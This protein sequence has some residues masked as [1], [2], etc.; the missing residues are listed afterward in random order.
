[1]IYQTLGFDVTGGVL[2]KV[3]ESLYLTKYEIKSFII[4]G[5]GKKNLLKK[6]LLGEKVLGTWII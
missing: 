5:T 1:L 4:N 6:A 3:K 2:H